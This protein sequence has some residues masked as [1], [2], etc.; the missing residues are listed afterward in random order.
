MHT[1]PSTRLG[2]E[3][4]AD[5]GPVTLPPALTP[6]EEEVL[7]Q[8]QMRRAFAQA[9]N[10]CWEVLCIRPRAFRKALKPGD[11]DEEARR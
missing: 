1:K 6:A 10:P 11:L 3:S 4:A 8:Q 7:G 5:S 2:L 9:C